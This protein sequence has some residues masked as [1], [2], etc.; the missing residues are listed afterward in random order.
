MPEAK[1]TAEEL[2]RLLS[3]EFPRM[4]DREKGVSIL[5]VWHRGALV[6]QGFHP[7]AL[8]PGGTLSGVAMMGLADLAMYIAVLASI[9]W[10]PLAVTTNLNINFLNKPPP[11]ALEGECRL[12]K[13]GKRLAVGEIGIRSE[14]ES[15]LVAHAT[16][17][18]AMPSTR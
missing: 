2:E 14:G 18:Y 15:E 11:R 12:I 1:L 17:T 7:R 13:L 4:F 10:A 6:R 16:S 3:A 8:R 9:G 5:K